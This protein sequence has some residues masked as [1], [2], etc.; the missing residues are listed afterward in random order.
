MDLY[1]DMMYR[2]I[3]KPFTASWPARLT[4]AGFSFGRNNLNDIVLCGEEL[5][6]LMIFYSLNQIVHLNYG[7]I[8]H[9]SFVPSLLQGSTWLHF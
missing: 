3:T 6:D 5:A 2:T 4:W 9:H 7:L 8:R 1:S